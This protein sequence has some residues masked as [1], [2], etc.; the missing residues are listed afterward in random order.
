VEHGDRIEQTL[1]ARFRARRGIVIHDVWRDDP[2]EGGLVR[3]LECLYETAVRAACSDRTLLTPESDLADDG[4]TPSRR[5]SM[6]LLGCCSPPNA[7]AAL[8]EP[9]D[10]F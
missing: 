7:T 1:S 2:L 3:R 8:N 6:P 9:L 5:E 10:Y 4:T